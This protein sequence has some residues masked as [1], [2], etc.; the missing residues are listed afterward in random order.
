MGRLFKK[1]IL[2]EISLH[3]IKTRFYCTIESVEKNEK[4]EK[5]AL[6]NYQGITYLHM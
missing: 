6:K 4:Y 1:K 5:W 3:N 2:L